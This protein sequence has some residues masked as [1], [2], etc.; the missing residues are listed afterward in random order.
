MGADFYPRLTAVANNHAECNR[1]VNEQAEVGLLIAGPGLLATLTC[2]PLVIALFYS[3]DF[4]PAAE[5]LRWICL[6][7]FL[8]VITWPLGFIVLAKGKRKMFFWTELLTNSGSAGLI[9]VCVHFFGLLGSGI[10]FFILYLCHSVTVYLLARYLTGFR[11]STANRQLALFFAPLVGVVFGG[12][13]LLPQIPA[14]ILGLVVTVPVSIYCARTL[15]KLIPFE[16]LPRMGQKLIRMLRLA[17]SVP[18]SIPLASEK[19]I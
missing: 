6:G 15:L 12:W 4:A 14:L 2:A 18:E 11:W 9:W 19:K 10:A 8:Q 5:I 13:Y 7:M 3:S 16:R 1:L 17:P